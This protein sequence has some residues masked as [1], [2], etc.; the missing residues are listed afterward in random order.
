[1]GSFANSIGNSN[2]SGRGWRSNIE[3]IIKSQEEEMKVKVKEK[4]FKREKSLLSKSLL[5]GH[6]LLLKRVK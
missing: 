4:W 3:N 2:A 5:L 6:L 1:M